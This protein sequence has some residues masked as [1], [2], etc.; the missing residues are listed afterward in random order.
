M[1]IFDICTIWTHVDEY[2]YLQS[3]QICME[4][5]IENR[6]SDSVLNIQGNEL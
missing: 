4:F 5:Y 3:S 1:T 2:V 6:S